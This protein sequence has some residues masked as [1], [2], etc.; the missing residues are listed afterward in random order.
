MEITEKLEKVKLKDA[1]ELKELIVDSVGMKELLSL[2]YEGIMVIEL[3][4]RLKE[5]NYDYAKDEASKV[6]HSYKKV[7]SSDLFKLYS[8]NPNLMSWVEKARAQGLLEDVPQDLTKIMQRG[9]YR[10]NVYVLNRVLVELDIDEL[11]IID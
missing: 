9:Q 8:D 10:Y 6:A 1:K 4:E 5:G 2:G 7:Y 11:D 3:L